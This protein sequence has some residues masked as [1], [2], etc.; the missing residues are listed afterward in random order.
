M[1]VLASSR[2]VDEYIVDEMN[3]LDWKIVSAFKKRA[4]RLS[5]H[6]MKSCWTSKEISSVR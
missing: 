1:E 4:I 5:S 2:I 3:L 6:L